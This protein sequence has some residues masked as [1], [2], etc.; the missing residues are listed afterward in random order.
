M[1][2]RHA[3]VLSAVAGAVLAAR[4]AAAQEP[5]MPAATEQGVVLLQ[6]GR[7]LQGRVEKLG[8]CY[9]V[10]Q[11]DGEI[12]VRA[13]EVQFVCRDL[14]EGYQRKRATLDPQ[15]V[16]AHLQL[17]QWCQRQGLL[18]AAAVELD[19]ARQIDPSNP[20]VDTLERRLQMALEA[21]RDPAPPARPV[22]A[23]PTNEELDRMVRGMPPGTVETFIQSTQPILLNH[24]MTSGCHGG[25]G[26]DRLQWI[27]TPLSQPPSRRVT[28]RNLYATLRWIDWENPG[29]SPLLTAAGGP[30]GHLPAAVFTDRQ[31]GQYRRLAEWVYRVAQKPLP[32]EAGGLAPVGLAAASGFA[33]PSSPR[34]LATP[35]S[36]A[37]PMPRTRQPG[38]SNPVAAAAATVPLAAADHADAGLPPGQSSKTARSPRTP[39]PLERPAAKSQPV[40]GLDPYDPEVVNR[41]VF[42]A[43][44]QSAPATMPTPAAR[45]LGKP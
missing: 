5:A 21:P 4:A 39:R 43:D 13:S 33:D 37:R 11:A 36:P 44:A 24:C 16:S 42:P 28:Q 2:L 10:S 27:R 30:H 12:R 7:V 14:E 45:A 22:V 15:D 6:N 29:N 38:G 31:F 18:R 17:A 41:Q 20:L 34:N 1:F 23:G 35:L 19:A 25:R 40:E 3:W 26:E 9:R 32:A 8:E